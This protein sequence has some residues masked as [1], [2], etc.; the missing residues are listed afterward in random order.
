MVQ[1]DSA[2][3]EIS[4]EDLPTFEGAVR[5]RPHVKD[6]IDALTLNADLLEALAKAKDLPKMAYRN[7]EI[8][9]YE[10]SAKLIFAALDWLA[11]GLHVAAGDNVAEFDLQFLGRHFRR[12]FHRRTLDVSSFAL[13]AQPSKWAEDRLPGFLL[14]GGRGAL[15]DARIVIEILRRLRN[16]QRKENA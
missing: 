1:D 4:I 2:H 13:G 9:I 7:R 15:S 3:P 8:D 10:N 5:Y 16:D 11:P 14:L 6:S 12:R